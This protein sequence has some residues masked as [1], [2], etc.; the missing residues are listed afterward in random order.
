MFA[1]SGF[2]LADDCVARVRQQRHRRDR[3]KAASGVGS[4][5]SR[6]RDDCRHC[7]QR[8]NLGRRRHAKGQDAIGPEP[9]VLHDG[10]ARFLRLASERIEEIGEAVLMECARRC[11]ARRDREKGG[12]GAS[13]HPRGRQQHS[14]ANRSHQ[15]AGKRKILHALVQPLRRKAVQAWR[16]QPRQE[17]DRAQKIAKLGSIIRIIDQAQ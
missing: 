4:D 12:Q 16:W 6:R 7:G 13:P 9:A 3:G 2:G 11:R 14:G 8:K 5:K 15:D 17:L 10:E 1:A